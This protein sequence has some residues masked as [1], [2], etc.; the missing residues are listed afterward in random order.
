[1]L[2]FRRD[3][4]LHDLP[5]LAAALK[6]GPVLPLFVLDDRLTNGRWPSPNRAAHLLGCLRALDAELKARGNRLYIRRGRPEVEVPKFVAE[7]G[8]S[9]V[10]VSRDYSPFSRRRDAKV[11]ALLSAA[12]VGF[13][14]RRGTLA[15]EPEQVLT[16]KGE[17][18]SV[19]SPFHRR[20][21]AT[22]L[23]EMIPAPEEIAESRKP[24]LLGSLPALSDLARGKPSPHLIEPGEPAALRRLEQWVR[25]DLDAYAQA[26]DSLGSEATSRLS[27]DLKWGTLSPLQV[28]GAARA[29]HPRS[30]SRFVTEVAWREFYA[31]VL[32][33]N[34]RVLRE[35]FRPEFAHLRWDDPADRFE[36]WKS[37]QTGY[38][39]VDAAM[40]QLLATGFMHN[41]ARMIVASFL[42]KD[43]HLDWRLGEAHFMEYL[44]DGDVA[45][46]NGGWQ[47]AAS[48][49]TDPQPY[50]RIFNPTLQAGRFDP[51]GAYVRRWVP[52]L[53]NVPERF[54]HEPWRMSEGGQDAAG[55]QIGRDYPPPIVDHAVERKVAIARYTE[56]KVAAKRS[57]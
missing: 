7:A 45:N 47:W 33:H 44:V 14:A 25:G 31:H 29:A 4:R 3:L 2:W 39:V 5:A 16:D 27:Q 28:I 50:F 35:P 13:H 52:E 23:P 30:S 1:M 11:H 55:C 20:W 34:P 43:L 57:G 42:T 32:W 22:D 48:T 19:F 56:A 38:P 40:R 26:R 54:I 24:G 49:G 53:A 21:Q 12:G 18:Y 6:A 9:G 46:N 37:G 51:D 17:P 8:A 10:F 41:R 15:L 36:A